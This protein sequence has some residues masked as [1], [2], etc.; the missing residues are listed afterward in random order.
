VCLQSSAHYY[1]SPMIPSLLQHL[2]RDGVARI[3]GLLLVAGE[4][5]S[6]IDGANFVAG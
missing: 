6:N 1:T 2:R 4:A 3:F 5:F